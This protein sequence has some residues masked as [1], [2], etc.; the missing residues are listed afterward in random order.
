[1]SNCEHHVVETYV[2]GETRV[3]GIWACADCKIR[4]YP[5]DAAERSAA[6]SKARAAL[7]KIAA[8]DY[9]GN[10]PQEQQ[11]AREALAKVEEDEWWFA[12]R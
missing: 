9:R 7:E 2:N 11:I 4:F 12:N 10:M 6:A 1:M 5:H 8:M 3:P